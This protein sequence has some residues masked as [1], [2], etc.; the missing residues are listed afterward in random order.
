MELKKRLAFALD[1]PA[2]QVSSMLSIFGPKVG[3]IKV[4]RAFLAGGVQLMNSIVATGA[5]SF[6]DL[7]WK[8][9]PETVEGYIEEA[10]TSMKLG[11][12][13][14]HAMG[15]YTMMAR[16]HDYLDKAF[17]DNPLER[18]LM[19]A[20]T[21]LT[22]QNDDDLKDMG[23]KNVSTTELSLNL[24]QMAKKAGCDGV[25][26][27]APDV[28][29]IR[30]VVGKSF[31]IVTPAIRFVDATV[32]ND[33]QKRLASPDAAIENGSDILVMGRPLIQGGLEAVQKAYDL[34]EKGLNDRGY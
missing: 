25:V 5:K 29:A 19:I 22:S 20:V 11:M 9:I 8:D 7:K 3:W 24:A 23:I 4:N 31:V 28:K 33:D 32:A 26:A 13:N 34:I 27:A 18:P 12:F 21:L 2:A 14:V 17:T 10:T 16:C 6:L 15:G 1:V 30:E